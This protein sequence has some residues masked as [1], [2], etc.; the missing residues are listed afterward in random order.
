MRERWIALALLLAPGL[1]AAQTPS[2]TP[3][4]GDEAPAF[5]EEPSL[6]ALVLTTE[7]VET[8]SFADAM[9]RALSRNTTVATAN[10]ELARSRALLEEA[11]ASS[12]PSITANATYTRLDAPRTLSQGAGQPPRVIAGQ[13]QLSANVVASVPLFVPGRWRSWGHAEDAVLAASASAE[14]VRRTI[15]LATARAY[16]AVSTQRRLVEVDALAV[17][18]AQAHR[19]FARSRLSGGVGNRVDL[20]RAEQTLASAQSRLESARTGLERAR[21]ALGVLLAADGPLDVQP[22]EL[23]AAPELQQALTEAPRRRGDLKALAE[24]LHISNSIAHDAWTDYTPIVT[25]VFQPFYQDPA[26]LTQPQTGWQAQV[27]FSWPLYDGGFRYG[28]ERENRLLATEARL[29]F[30]NATRGAYA[31]I[32]GDSQAVGHAGA[33]LSAAQD[34]A[35][36]AHQVL[37]LSTLSYRAGAATNIEVIDAERQALDADTAAALAEGDALQA[38][39]DLLAASGRLP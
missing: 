39:M 10:A 38:R 5:E 36:L 34:A 3:S 24:R 22:F 32:R 28:R 6:P 19:D 7:S 37:D 20:V 21:E 26:S 14:D 31:E 30:E 33:A 18:S 9:S 1:A 25:G 17:R 16:L 11:R 29:A 35:K 23:P 15:T 8:I 4:P 13:D 27:L 12:L 2:P